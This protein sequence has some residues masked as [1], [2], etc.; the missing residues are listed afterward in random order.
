MPLLQSRHSYQRFLLL[1]PSSQSDNLIKRR[2]LYGEF[3]FHYPTPH[4]RK[5]KSH[6]TI[7][8]PPHTQVTINHFHIKPKFPRKPFNLTQPEFYSTITFTPSTYDTGNL[9]TTLP[10][11]IST[12]P[13]LSLL[14]HASLK[15]PIS[16]LRRSLCS[17]HPPRTY[18][19]YV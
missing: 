12:L 18:E 3:S 11:P 16:E 2:P 5:P 19:D 17:H 13:S 15:P 10:S 14:N 7:N 9:F 4:T 8:L 6:I 1:R